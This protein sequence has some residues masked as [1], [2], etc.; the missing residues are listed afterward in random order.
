VNQ[1]PS[2]DEPTAKRPAVAL[3]S[4]GECPAWIRGLLALL[5]LYFFLAA[6]NVMGGGLKMLGHGGW[7][8][9]LLAHGN[10]PFIALMGSVL[11]TAIVQSSSFT[12]A[13]IITL[14]ASG[15][16]ELRTAV[17]AIMGA[18]IGTSVTGILVS[19]GQ[20]R[21]RQQFHRAF[22]AA[23]VHDI[24]NWL[25]V[26]LIFPIEWITGSMS[27]TG[28]GWLTR[29]A[30]WLT[31][32]LGLNAMDK[33]LNPVKW[34]T[35]PVV[36]LMKRGGELVVHD[37]A[38]R[39]T[40]IAVVGLVMLFTALIFLVK[41]LKGALL[42]RI[43]AMFRTVLFRNDATAYAVGTV[44][45]VLVQ[46]SSVTT[47]LIIPLAGAG[48][49]TIRRVFPFVLGANLGTT[50]TGVIAATANPVPAA[51]TVALVHVMFN[52]IGTAIWYPLRG[53]P[54]MLAEGYATLAARSRIYAFLFLFVVFVILPLV[55]L[56]VTEILL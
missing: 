54:I 41:N 53:I 25:T 49:V 24:F 40:V 15:Q 6:I 17:F 22:S 33:P 28:N 8:E 9:N 19:L 52:L 30:I 11:I 21:I 2:A 23:L 36:S 26:A 27:E 39:G 29:M 50:V 20:M 16:M 34:I 46:S 51:V 12:T 4:S 32:L 45:T 55:G 10:N 47:S 35:K 7:L 18:N 3:D 38:V 42:G 5:S 14:V 31:D 48:A 1:S 43:E 56:G 37:E 13:M 44:M